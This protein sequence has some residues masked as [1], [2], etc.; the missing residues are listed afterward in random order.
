M[1][2]TD[3]LFEIVNLF[4]NGK[5]WT[6]AQLAEQ[7][8]VSV[9]T[10]YRDIDTLV[11][12]GIP[13]EGE[14]GIGYLV[15]G[16]IF[17]PTMTLTRDEYDALR[18]GVTLVQTSGDTSLAYA[19]DSLL[20]KLESVVPEKITTPPPAVVAYNDKFSKD[21]RFLPEVR[22]AIHETRR[23]WIRYSNA[24][25]EFSERIVRPLQ[26]EFWGAWL[27][28]SWCE[29][30]QGFRL[31]RVDRI[32]ALRVEE[33]YQPEPGKSLDDYLNYATTEY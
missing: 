13:I 16:E 21:V 26:I 19:A 12:S 31:F 30:R 20:K 25:D 17:L 29:L 22:K 2:R 3:R 14:R 10:I 24:K 18:F 23:I 9:R 27:M 33:I 28:A 8:E 5:V 7:L 15:R 4:R 11:A 6:S 32:S 1:R